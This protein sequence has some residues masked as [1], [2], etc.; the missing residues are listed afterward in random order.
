MQFVAAVDELEFILALP[1]VRGRRLLIAGDLNVEL[2]RN[3]LGLTGPM[4]K[5]LFP[6]EDMMSRVD[7]ILGLMH[8]HTLFAKTTEVSE[9]APGSTSCRALEL[10]TWFSWRDRGCRQGRHLDYILCSRS[11]TGSNGKLIERIL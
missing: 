10:N 5:R 8:K 1:T 4:A 6:N 3:Q 9:V 11:A 7:L 2:P